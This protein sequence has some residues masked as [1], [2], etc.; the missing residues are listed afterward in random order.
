LAILFDKEVACTDG[1]TSRVY[2]GPVRKR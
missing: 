2:P 1:L